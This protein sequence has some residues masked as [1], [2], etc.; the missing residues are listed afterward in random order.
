MSFN[1]ALE[2]TGIAL[3]ESN[4]QRQLQNRKMKRGRS[5]DCVNVALQTKLLAESDIPTFK[6]DTLSSN[7]SWINWTLLTE[8]LMLDRRQIYCTQN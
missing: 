8:W 7:L 2:I 1:V 3:E 6:V 5:T 4:I